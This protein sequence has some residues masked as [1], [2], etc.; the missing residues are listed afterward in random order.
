MRIMHSVLV[1]GRTD[2]G[3]EFQLPCVKWLTKC[4]L[5]RQMV[6]RISSMC[7]ERIV[8]CNWNAFTMW[9]AYMYAKLLFKSRRKQKKKVKYSTRSWLEFFFFWNGQSHY[10]AMLLTLGLSYFN[11]TVLWNVQPPCNIYKV[12]NRFS[13]ES[14]AARKVS[15]RI[16]S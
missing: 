9:H 6:N 10:N 12:I 16:N 4:F 15:I 8:N 7:S 13:I 11:I 14:G 1:H 2:D 5:W 3:M